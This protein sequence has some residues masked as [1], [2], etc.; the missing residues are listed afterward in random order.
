V[1]NGALIDRGPDSARVVAMV[2]R[3]LAQAGP[4]RVRVTFG[5]HEMGLLTPDRFGW[6]GWYSRDRSP[7]ER[8]ALVDRVRMGHV[9][10]AYRGYRVTCAHAGRPHPYDAGAVNDQLVGA[11]TDLEP[12]IGTPND[13]EAQL[14]AIEGY[15]EVLGLGG[16]TGRGPGA[17]VAW[18]DF[19]HL[20]AD[21]PPQVSA[22]RATT[23]RPARGQSPAR[24]SSGTTCRGGVARRCSSRRQTG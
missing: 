17:D 4:E 14:A 9:V 6:V 3:L 8:R 23:S 20:P 10:A 15:P 1:F 11:A 13:R 21:A 16:R 5:N 18:L 2:A 24:T 12:A 7:A 19:G 22:T